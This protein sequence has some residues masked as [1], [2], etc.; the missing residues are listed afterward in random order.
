MA[1]HTLQLRCDTPQVFV[2]LP[3]DEAQH[4]LTTPGVQLNLVLL[5]DQI[6]LRTEELDPYMNGVL[7][8]HCRKEP[9]Y[10]PPSLK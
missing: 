10:S 6:H 4:A 2:G 7:G 1:G 9:W 3:F 8:H 5:R